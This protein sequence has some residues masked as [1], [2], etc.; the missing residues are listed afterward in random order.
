MLRLELLT[1]KPRAFVSL[2]GLTPA[3][4]EA[5]YGVFAPTYARH[6]AAADTTRRDRQLRHR[7]PGAGAPYALDLRHRLLLALVC[8]GLGR[9]AQPEPA[10]PRQAPAAPRRCRAGSSPS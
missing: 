1:A 7:A 9:V 3:E 5:L 6:R 10:P 8:W 4:F 2:T